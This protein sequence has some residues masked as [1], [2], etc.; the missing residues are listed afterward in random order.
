MV[1]VGKDPNT[2]RPQTS[3]GPGTQDGCL[4][5]QFRQ[6]AVVAAHPF[7]VEQLR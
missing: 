5:R 1:P 6:A 7:V 3:D 4:R 2:R